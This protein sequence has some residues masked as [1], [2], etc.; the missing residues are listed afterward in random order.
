MKYVSEGCTDDRFDNY[1][2][3]ATQDSN[4]AC[5]K[6]GCTSNW[7]DNFDPLATYNDVTT[8]LLAACMSEWADNYD[9]NA[10]SDNGSC[11]EKV[12]W[13]ITWITMIL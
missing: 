5:I 11:F 8:C 10:T 6:E 9:A 12:V 4:D 13:L 7:A 3:L 2:S 1:D